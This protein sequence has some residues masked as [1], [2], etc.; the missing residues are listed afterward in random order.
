MDESAYEMKQPVLSI[1]VPT[2]NAENQLERFFLSLKRQI[3][4]K[5]SLE[6]LM[7]DGG[8]TDK[9]LR[10]AKKYHVRVIHNPM[11]LAEP[12]VVLGCTKAKGE[13]VMVL[14]TDN[15]YKE[16]NALQ[17]IVDVFDDKNVIAAFPKHDTAPDDSV[18]SRYFNTFTDPFSHFVYGKA[19]NARTF[20]DIY[21]T[22]R[23]TPIFDIYDYTSFSE[24]P[25]IALAQGFTIRRSY[26]TNRHETNDDILA[27]Y[28]L[29]MQKKQIAYVHSVSLYH[30][31][32]DNFKVF[33]KKQSRAV[34]N[35][36]VRKNSGISKRSNYLTMGQKI[37][38]YFYFPYALSII[39]PFIRSL[40]E[41]INTGETMWF[42]HPYMVFISAVVIIWK[43]SIISLQQLV[44]LE[45]KVL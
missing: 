15:I 14:A 29:I 5:N 28:E 1:V 23:H 27:I 20:K 18:Y 38:Q 31:T 24:L 21:H 39:L 25:V 26:L 42:W 16:R 40:Y 10:I 6:I 43:M 17:T 34:E 45:R 12:G 44:A 2:Y 11:K 4:P 30:Y 8:S 13:M 36:I 22:I 9:S 7:I 19:A 41:W 37:K 3:F 33:V 35:A 32:A